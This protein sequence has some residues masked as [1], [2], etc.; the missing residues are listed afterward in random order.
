LLA[1]EIDYK[2]SK[3]KALNEET[4]EI[5]LSIKELV[6]VENT[7]L[8]EFS[9][10][11]DIAR[12]LF[13]IG[14]YTSLRVFDFSNL[15]ESNMIEFHGKKFFKVATQKTGEPVVIPIHPVVNRILEKRNGNLPPRLTKNKI[16]EYWK[17]SRA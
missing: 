4:D 11:I 2:N 14:A 3:F 12:D 7:D 17:K 9:E 5:Y 15:S 6:K 10:E 16:N 1:Y 8:S 13:L